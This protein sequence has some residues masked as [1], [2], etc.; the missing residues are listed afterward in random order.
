[1]YP[2]ETIHMCDVNVNVIANGQIRIIIVTS[3]GCD[4]TRVI[5]SGEKTGQ[6]TIDRMRETE[7][8]REKGKYNQF[9]CSSKQFPKYN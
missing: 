4:R 1:M 2:N 3:F 7:S 6:H 8:E 9:K 5:N